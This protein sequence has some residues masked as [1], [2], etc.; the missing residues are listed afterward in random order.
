M[1]QPYDI[2]GYEK[3]FL[4][5]ARLLHS[6]AGHPNIVKF[7]AIASSQ[8]YALM[9][10]YEMFTF[11][12]FGDDKVV[13]SLSRFLQHVDK[14]YDFEGFEHIPLVIAKQVTEGLKFLHEKDIVH[15]DLKPDNVLVSNMHYATQSGD[16]FLQTWNL[17]DSPIICKLTDFGE[18]R[19]RLIQ[20]Q[21]LV[22]SKVKNV[23]R[24]SPAYMSPEILIPEK[25]PS[26]VTFAVLKAADVWAYGMIFFITSNPSVAYPYAAEME[27][28]MKEAPLKDCR[29]ILQDILRSGHSPNMTVKYTKLQASFWSHILYLHERCTSFDYSNRFLDIR[30]VSNYLMES[31]AISFEH[32]SLSIHQGS[33]VEKKNLIIAENIAG[34]FEPSGKF[35]VTNDGTN[36]C[37]FL[38]LKICDTVFTEKSSGNQIQ[39]QKAFSD[40]AEEVIWNYPEILNPLRDISSLY[41]VLDAY[42]LMRGNEHL[43]NILGI[44]EELLTYNSVFSSV[45]RAALISKLI[46]LAEKSDDFLSIF[47]C[48]PYSIVIGQ[49]Q[50]KLFIL[51]TH[52]VPIEC[53]GNGNA[54]M[55]VYDSNTSLYCRCVSEWLW[56]RLAASGVKD[57]TGQSL[58]VIR[59]EEPTAT[60]QSSDKAEI[61]DGENKVPLNDLTFKQDADS[62]SDSA[63]VSLLLY[64]L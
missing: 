17:D 24:G 33:A 4:K 39:T 46:D 21:T 48:E 16:T 30:E 64:L 63:S 52:A 15:R 56:N 28:A 61:S 13:S 12:P 34:G 10:E 14:H 50:K 6:V 22:S 23:A 45:S 53:G 18:S 1:K 2:S 31:A 49:F 36:A 42:T 20:T 19:S 7:E 51:D 40:I 32:Y 9:E 55:R 41:T 8:P 62:D 60:P 59:V 47:T 43:T 26:P 58:A 3:E 5:E 29:E 25:R 57:D 11:K 35:E 37:V 38:A 44:S 27:E 54:G